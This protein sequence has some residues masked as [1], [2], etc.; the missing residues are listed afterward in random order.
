MDLHVRKG[1]EEQTCTE[2][3]PSCSC[4]GGAGPA[5]EEVNKARG[6]APQPLSLEV[7]MSTLKDSAL[8][9]SGL[10][11]KQRGCRVAPGDGRRNRGLCTFLHF[12]PGFPPFSHICALFSLISNVSQHIMFSE[13][14]QTG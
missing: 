3:C 12:S 7:R 6:P 9:T 1:G 5:K 13:V 14:F 2:Q 11:R 10:H 4:R 8:Q